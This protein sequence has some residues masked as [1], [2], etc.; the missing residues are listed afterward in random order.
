MSY[1][2][3]MN[4]RRNWEWKQL[5]LFVGSMRLGL[6]LLL[7]LIGAMAA[8]TALPAIYRSGWYSGLLGLLCLNLVCCSLR[9]L[10]AWRRLI[11]DGPP[12][13]A[14]ERLEQLPG[15][16][17]VSVTASPAEVAERCGYFLRRQNMRLKCQAA[18]PVRQLCADKGIAGSWGILLAHVSVLLIACGAVWGSWY[19]YTMT[20]KL[21][22]GG[23]YTVTAG[24]EP[25]VVRLHQFSTEYYPDGS[26]SD[27]ISDIGIEAGGREVLRQAVK[28]NHPL[29]YHGIR[30]YQSSYGTAIKTVVADAAGQVVQQAAVAEQELLSLTGSTDMAILPVGYMPDRRHLR[31]Q[32]PVM[33]QAKNPYVLYV[34][35]N[36]GEEQSWGAAAL[37]QPVALG[38]GSG[39]VTFTGT[40]PFSGV[41]I[42]HDPGMPLVWLGFA[43][44][45]AGFFLG[46][47]VRYRCV[48]LA[49]EPDQG[50]SCV[51]FGGTGG[52]AEELGKKLHAIIIQGS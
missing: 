34:L 11:W 4:D 38:P 51:R 21:P 43:L 39:T 19:G 44:M 15:G 12:A 5:W 46:L 29:D 33:G 41:Q 1:R 24:Q 49:I 47:Y 25:F 31:D 2:T 8:G 30:L 16:Y 18:G 27:W 13:A 10:P 40:V 52:Q 42:K 17:R 45:A 35:Y 9:R 50:G 14:P 23:A 22:V 26:V 6:L 20:V 3:V 7:L 37:G 28:V 36:G 48:W 32:L